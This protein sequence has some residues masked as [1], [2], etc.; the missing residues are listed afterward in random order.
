MRKRMTMRADIERNVE[1]GV[2]IHNNPL[3]P[4][5][6]TVAE[7]VS[8]FV[9]SKSSMVNFPGDRTANVERLRAGFSLDEDIRAEDRIIRITNK[10]GT[11]VL[12][13]N[14]RVEPNPQF[15]HRHFEVD[16][17]RISQ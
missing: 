17:K 14:L 2:D 15:K 10:T 1:T 6:E 13:E 11:R 9:W 5:Y 12:Y 7:N 4:R 16:L 8:C 3:E